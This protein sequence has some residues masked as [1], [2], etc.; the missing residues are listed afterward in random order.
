MEKLELRFS[1]EKETRN[2]IRYQDA[3]SGEIGHVSAPNRPLVR[4]NLP[5]RKK[6]LGSSA[7]MAIV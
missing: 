6:G 2:T 3:D 1:Y 7:G 5:P 4:A